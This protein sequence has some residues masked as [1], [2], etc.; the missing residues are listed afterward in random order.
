MNSFN[1]HDDTQKVL[2]PYLFLLLCVLTSLDLTCIVI[3][4]VV[5][6]RL[7]RSTQTQILRF[8]PL[9]RWVNL[10]AIKRLVEAD[11][12]EMEIIRNPKEV[13]GVIFLKLQL[14]QQLGYLMLNLIFHENVEITHLMQFFLV[15]HFFDHAIGINVPL[16]RFLPVKASPDLLLVQSDLYTS[17]DGFSS[18]IQLEQI[19]QMLYIKRGPEFKKVANFLSLYKSIPSII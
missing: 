15:Y 3:P 8:T 16:S 7:L 13:D 14:V 9:I 1:T 12:L 2:D 4:V 17:I 6:L 11:A 10:K 18:E 19:L 5:Q